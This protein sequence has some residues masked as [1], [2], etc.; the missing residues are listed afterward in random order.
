MYPGL[1]NLTRERVE[2]I[3]QDLSDFEKSL[4]SYDYNTEPYA[5]WNDADVDSFAE[6]FI[7]NEFTCNYDVGA[8]ST[9]LYKD[10]RGKY[11]MCIWDMNSCCNNFHDSQIMPQHFQMQNITWFYMMMKDENF[12]ER[13]IERYWELR[14]TFLSEEYLSQYID[15][16]IEYLGPAIGRNFE[17]WGYSFEEY[18][19]LP[20]TAAT[21]MTMQMRLTS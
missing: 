1:G 10:I 3:E 12:V 8:R 17:V 5:W 7:I 15:Q 21:R 14:E 19:P 16:T 6:Y 11:K 2:W 9:Y 13:I 4:Y 20:R 18:R